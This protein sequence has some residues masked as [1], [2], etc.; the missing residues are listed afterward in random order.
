MKNP[1]DDHHRVAICNNTL[2]NQQQ[3]HRDTSSKQV[4]SRS[5]LPVPS[6]T[7]QAVKTA[8]QR[9]VFTL[10][11][12]IYTAY[13]E[14]RVNEE[15]I[16]RNEKKKGLL[17]FLKHKQQQKQQQLKHVPCHAEV[18]E[19]GSCVRTATAAST[20]VAVAPR[21]ARAMSNGGRR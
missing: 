2:R 3:Q 18:E 7:Q 15:L 17:V 8:G 20:A 9:E 5:N 10:L 4:F 12:Q 13:G 16:T 19:G 14:L 1:N 6:P 21:T 11:Y